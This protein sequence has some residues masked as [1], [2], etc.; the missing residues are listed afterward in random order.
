MPF[1]EEGTVNHLT[2]NRFRKSVVGLG[3]LFA[4][5]LFVGTAPFALAADKWPTWPPK[6]EAP[7]PTESPKGTI[8][9]EPVKEGAPSEAKP[10]AAAPAP[11]APAAEAAAKAGAAAGKSASA[12]ISSGTL[13]WAAAII[14]AGVL[15]GVAA[16]GG[17]GSTSNH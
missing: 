16:G 15:I 3:S 10:A 7:A 2:R 1:V 6:K 17:G 14:G 5:L 8:T 13:G 9:E 11:A 12:G 4:F